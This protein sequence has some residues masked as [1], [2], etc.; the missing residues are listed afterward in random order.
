[1]KTSRIFCLRRTVSAF[2]MLLA[3]VMAFMGA[4]VAAEQPILL[5]QAFSR[6]FIMAPI[7][8]SFRA[9]EVQRHQ[10]RTQLYRE[11][12][13]ELRKNPAAADVGECPAGEPEPDEVC[14]RAAKKEDVSLPSQ[15][16]AV[17]SPDAGKE[18]GALAA[19]ENAPL[20]GAEQ[21]PSPVKFR[22][23]AV[24]FGN[25]GYLAPIPSL[26][27]PISDVQDIGRILQER[28]GYE[29]RIVRDAKKSDV[30]ST[31]NQLGS[32]TG[33]NDSVLV[34]YAGHGYLMDDTKMG[35]WIPVDGSVKSPANWVSNTD[36]TKF[37]KNI[38]AKQ[39]I[40]V[41][42]SCFS[43][44]LTR[45]E[46]MSDSSKN[47]D[48]GSILERRSVLVMSSGGE[49]PVS[50]EGKEGH[51]IFAWSLIN[52]LK[53]VQ[54]MTPGVRIF[55]I[56]KDEVVKDYPQEPQYGAVLSAGHME[57]GEYLFETHAQ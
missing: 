36:I 32:E 33:A 16:E 47:L 26:E 34:V 5:A 17:S 13:D 38:Q 9:I 11:A 10:S 14:I 48:R 41:S 2:G 8:N 50:D 12:L 57:G 35:Y 7:L 1:M 23:F 45:E 21:A 25:N 24:L 4:A 22:K 15:P 55:Q 39:V 40:L 27:T 28:F 6:P 56:V 37:L 49:E 44:S 52:A 42:D 53:S 30:V 18:P 29:V 19:A 43:G 46:K 31:L 54:A 20:A 3:G 51:S